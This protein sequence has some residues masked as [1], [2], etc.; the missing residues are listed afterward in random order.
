MF[1]NCAAASGV[2]MRIRMSSDSPSV[3]L[4]DPNTALGLTPMPAAFSKIFAFPLSR[5]H[6]ESPV[7]TLPY[8][9]RNGGDDLSVEP[10]CATCFTPAVLPFSPIAAT[11]VLSLTNIT[12]NCSLF[13]PLTSTTSP[14]RVTSPPSLVSSA[15]VLSMHASALVLSIPCITTTPSGLSVPRPLRP[16]DIDLN[17]AIGSKSHF[18]L[19]SANLACTS[20]LISLGSTNCFHSE[21]CWT[22]AKLMPSTSSESSGSR[23]RS[24]TAAEEPDD[25]T[26]G[27]SPFSAV[28]S[29][30][31]LAFL[32]SLLHAPASASARPSAATC[33]P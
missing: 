27:L 9:S 14:S 32:S 33:Q 5:N 26:P 4:S 18:A 24:S 2:S 30:G 23:V 15:L 1:A 11:A 13:L 20:P 10:P 7:L 16:T 6:S 8:M 12:A 29:P 31:A 3:T 25:A 17:D 19:N 22:C 28:L 21:L